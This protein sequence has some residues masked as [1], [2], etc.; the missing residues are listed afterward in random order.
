MSN[1][2]VV[3]MIGNVGT[4]PEQREFESGA[5]VTKFSI[6]VSRWNKKDQKDVTDWF[7]VETFSKLGDYI[8]KGLKVCVNGQM[9]TNVYEK[10]GNKIKRYYILANT[11]EI[12]TKKENSETETS[13]NANANEEMPEDLGSN[14]DYPEDENTKMLDEEENAYADIIDE[15]EIPFN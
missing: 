10:D 14:A 13:A 3:T 8:K 15:D 2:N 5:K 7:D 6:G 1:L 11:V 4:E 9:I 12:L